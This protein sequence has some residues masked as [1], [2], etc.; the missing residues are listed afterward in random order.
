MR[1]IQKSEMGKADYGWLN[2]TYHFSFAQ[3][4]NPRNMR[5]GVLRVLNDDWIDPRTGFDTHPHSDMEILTYV[6][7]GKL[8][9]GDSMGNRSTLGRGD[10]QYMSAGTGVLHSE[11]NLDD[12]PLHLLQLWILPRAKGLS[13]KYG[14]WTPVWEDRVNTWLHIAGPDGSTDAQVGLRQDAS[15]SVSW[16]EAGQDLAYSVLDGRQAYLVLAEGVAEV[17]GQAMSAGDAMEL[18]SG[19]ILL[20]SIEDSHWLI[21][22]M[23]AE[24]SS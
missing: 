21:V 14:D 24:P 11:H 1:H 4:F 23:A 18:R 15:I 12:E 9:H 5:F 2:T 20:H 16:L 6:L 3:Y 8:T 13:P 19:D 22:E 17:N 7:Q 10:V